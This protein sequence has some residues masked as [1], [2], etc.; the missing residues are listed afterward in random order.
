M[1]RDACPDLVTHLP[2]LNRLVRVDQHQNLQDQA[3]SY[4]EKQDQL[5]QS[6]YYYRSTETKSLRNHE[7]NPAS[8]DIAQRVSNRITQVSERGR[9]LTVALNNEFSIL[10]D[11]PNRLQQ[12]AHTEFPGL[13]R[14]RNT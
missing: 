11:F 13:R 7:S 14:P 10:K 4:Q 2:C 12:D 3:V 8:D 6:K 1:L 9:S 5:R